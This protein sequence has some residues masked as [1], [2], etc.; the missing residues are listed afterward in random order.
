[1]GWDVFIS[2]A[3]EDKELVA[4]PLARELTKRGFKVWYDEYTLK[5]GDKLRRSIEDGLAKSNFGIVI[6][7][8]SF[9]AKE[10]PQR[11]LDGL[12]ARETQGS[13]VLLPVWHNISQE[14]V[15]VHSPMLSD[16]LAADTSWG[17]LTIVEQILAAKGTSAGKLPESK[18]IRTTRVNEGL[19]ELSLIDVR[20]KPIY[21]PSTT[22]RVFDAA[23]LK[24][25]YRKPKTPSRQK[26][27]VM[28]PAF[29]KSLSL[30]CVAESSLY[31]PRAVCISV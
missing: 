25:V 7:S 24:Q 12:V 8:P 10:W 6:L 18:R 31:R 11:E 5:I 30:L 19:L 17:M 16:R 21:D 14:E 22:F 9:F 15:A 29:P 2:H 1:M 27:K 28:L 4:R 26:N 13:K 23:D 3:R 20:G